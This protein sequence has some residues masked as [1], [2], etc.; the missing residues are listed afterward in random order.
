MGELIERVVDEALVL[1]GCAVLD[2]EQTVELVVGVVVGDQASVDRFFVLATVA[3]GVVE[4]VVLTG[5]EAG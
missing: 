3:V 2:A 5:S 4:V 1:C